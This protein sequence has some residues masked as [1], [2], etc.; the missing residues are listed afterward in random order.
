MRHASRIVSILRFR[1]RTAIRWLLLGVSLGLLVAICP[2]EIFAEEPSAN[3][4]PATQPL[5]ILY[6]GQPDHS[7]TH[8][9]V[10][11]LETRFEKVTVIPFKELSLKTAADSDVVLIDIPGSDMET[12]R[13]ISLPERFDR[14]TVLVS[15]NGARLGEKIDIKLNDA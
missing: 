9:F 14:P 7:R 6:A 4:Q 2:S 15:V 12:F 11:F 13:R 5:R 1:E 8:E 3:S 10:Q